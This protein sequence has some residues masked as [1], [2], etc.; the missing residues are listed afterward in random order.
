MTEKKQPLGFWPAAMRIALL[1]HL[2]FVVALVVSFGMYGLSR[3]A[4][5]M[6]A[7]A[8]VFMLWANW[9]HNQELRDKDDER[10]A[11]IMAAVQQRGASSAGNQFSD[12]AD[13]TGR[14][15]AP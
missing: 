1:L 5:A 12:F 4:L 3:M 14:T 6:F 7:G 13:D 2:I 8:V 11:E 15:P 10:S 9:C